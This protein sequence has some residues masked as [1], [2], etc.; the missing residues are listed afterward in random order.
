M[1]VGPNK[2]EAL[3]TPSTERW[4]DCYGAFEARV[5]PEMLK[6]TIAELHLEQSRLQKSL[7]PGVGREIGNRIRNGD[8]DC[9]LQEIRR[10][11][12][13]N[14]LAIEMAALKCSMRETRTLASQSSAAQALF[15]DLGKKLTRLQDISRQGRSLPPHFQLAEH[16]IGEQTV[17]GKR[18]YS[19]RGQK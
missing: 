4:D 18:E 13:K 6:A 1:A 17:L 14:M 11:Y 7:A 19:E 16:F 12:R 2:E 10:H 5:R 15:D 3:G 8:L 9:W